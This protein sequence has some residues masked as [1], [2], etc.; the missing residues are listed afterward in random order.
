M[1][2][3]VEKIFDFWAVAEKLKDT[4]RWKS[5]PQMKQKET[6]ADH[7]WQLA[8]LVC[9][10]ISELE[11]DVDELKCLKLALV[12]DLVEA[13]TDDLDSV[14]VHSGEADG[15]SKKE[16]E[17]KAILEIVKILPKKSGSEIKNLWN[18]Y[19][20]RESLEAKLVHAL[21]K[22]ESISHFVHLGHESFHE[23]DDFIATYCHE[24]VEAFQGLT[25]FHYVLQKKLKSEYRKHG[26]GWRKEYNV[27]KVSEPALNKAKRIL[28]FAVIGEKLKSTRR[29][30][31]T[32]TMK[33][34]ESSAEHSWNLALL[35]FVAATEFKFQVDI[36]KS[37]KIALFHDIAEAIAG[38]V[39]ISLVHFG[40]ITKEQKRKR[41]LIAIKKIS[42]IIGEKSGKEIFNLWLEYENSLTPESKYVKAMDKIEGINHMLVLG[43]KCF[44]HPE[45]TAPH[46]IK[47]TR[48]FPLAI[49]LLRELHERLKPEYVKCN[50][51]WKEEYSI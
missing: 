30:L 29:F 37:I 23:H 12:H 22:L 41:E 17:K 3:K 24:P 9:V 20:E 45:L 11:L 34:K 21:D 6:V 44:D 35:S 1:A 13:I 18:E 26:W 50:W 5:V 10:A 47:A 27:P 49:P 33:K 51:A 14:L 28:K 16:E 40:V 39:D 25:P 48:N 36:L 46:P 43:Y 38:D 32:E 15:I 7:S 4:K 31:N 42:R 8:A 2:T 19:E